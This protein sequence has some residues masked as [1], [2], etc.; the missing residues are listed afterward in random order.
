MSVLDEV[1][2]KL[3]Y[4]GLKVIECFKDTGLDQAY[5]TNKIEEFSELSNYAA[6]H[7]ALRILDDSNMIR[8]AEKLQVTVDELNVTLK[9]LNKI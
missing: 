3:S 6:L 7:K 2:D 8:L 1:E 9:V 4:T 5:I